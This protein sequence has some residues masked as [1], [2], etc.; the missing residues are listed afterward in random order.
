MD[1]RNYPRLYTHFPAELVAGGKRA[2]DR[3]LAI[4]VSITGLQVVCDQR[5]AE[6]VVPKADPK[7][8]ASAKP[9]Q[10][11]VVLPLKDGTHVAVDVR[12]KLRM[13]RKHINAEYRLGLEY[14][15]FEGKSYSALEAFIDDWVEF[16]D[17]PAAR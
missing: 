11:R 2:I 12:C 13:V 5:V 1:R 8:V 14:D 4:D 10:I 9:V 15:F 7:K 17:E 16:P 3:V 6:R